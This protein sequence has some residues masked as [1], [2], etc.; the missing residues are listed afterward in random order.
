MSDAPRPRIRRE[1]AADQEAVGALLRA[2]YGGDAEAELL[3]R[4]RLD[5]AYLL[6]LVAE[7]PEGPS[8]LLGV[9]A[10]SQVD[11]AGAVGSDRPPATAAI[12]PL[13]VAPDRQNSG[14]GSALVQVGLA[15]C[16]KAGMDAALALGFP[17]FYQRFGFSAGAAKRLSGPWSGPTFVARPLRDDAPALEGDATYP[18][19]Y[20]PDDAA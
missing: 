13:A 17:R 9:I 15:Q 19:A 2:A 10:F 11:V 14:V 18:A 12:G 1:T 8:V 6:T 20:F 16:R 3:N 5:P 4:L 7:P